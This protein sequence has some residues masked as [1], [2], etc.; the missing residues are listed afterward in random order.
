MSSA[1]VLAAWLESRP[2]LDGAAIVGWRFEIAEGVGLRAGL[3][4]SRLGGPYE[5]PGLAWRL[6]GSLDLHWS[7]GRQSRVGLDRSA[8]LEPSAALP[9]WR[10]AAF[11]EPDGRLPPLAGPTALP[12]VETLDPAVARGVA[13]DPAV[14]LGILDQ[15]RAYAAGAGARRVD[16]VLRAS[17]GLRTVGTSRGFWTAWTETTCSLEL[18]VDEIAPASFGRRAL[19]DEARLDRMVTGAAALAHQLPRSGGASR[20]AAGR[21]PDARARRRD[22]R[23]AAAAEPL[24]PGDP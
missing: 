15:V 8:I 21:P 13:E 6:G 14:L 12:P 16:A 24:G 1:E 23:P 3:R 5:G 10:S 11:R 4:S 19:P 18:W 7:D 2:S 9:E 22:A 17:H 20:R